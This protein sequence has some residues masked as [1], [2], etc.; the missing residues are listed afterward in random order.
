MIMSKVTKETFNEKFGDMMMNGLDSLQTYIP[1]RTNARYGINVAI[2]PMVMRVSDGVVLY[3][4]KLRVGY[5]LDEKHRPVKT[6]VTDISGEV[7]VQRLQDFCKG[8]SW[9]KGDCHRFST[10]IGFGVAA[11][12][13]DKQGALSG[14]EENDTAVDFINRLESTYK[15]YN[16][17]SFGNNKAAAAAA[18]NDVWILQS[19]NPHIFKPLQ[20]F[21][22]LPEAVVG[23]QTK[24]LNKA[25]DKYRDNVVSFQKKIDDLA[26]AESEKTTS[27]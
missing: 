1:L 2:R 6:N 15:Q 13:F 24:M 26:E 16:G 19:Q 10:I 18:L 4:G 8:F 14:L 21:T 25:Q 7:K 3:G 5:T 23:T 11:T 12:K 17:V 9:Q 20:K 27:V 22:P